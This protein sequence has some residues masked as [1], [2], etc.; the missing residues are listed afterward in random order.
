MPDYDKIKQE[1][2]TLDLAQVAAAGYEALEPDDSYRLKTYGIC[3]QRHEGYFMIRIRVPHGQCSVA[4]LRQL[5]DLADRYSNGWVHITTR[6]DVQLHSVKLEDVP[7]L[8]AGLASVDLST[9]SSCGHTFR[10]IMGC[11]RA[12]TCADERINVRPWV[13]LVDRFVTDHADHFNTRM[14]SRL[15][16]YFA[17]CDTCMEHLQINDIGL[18]AVPAE[19][20]RSGSVS[21]EFELWLGGS[22]G[23]ANPTLSVR[24][25]DRLQPAEV[26]PAVYAVA[27]VHATRSKRHPYQGRLKYLLQSLGQDAL[28]DCIRT[29]LAEVRADKDFSPYELPASP[30][31]GFRSARPEGAN[32][33]ALP[34]GVEPQAQ[35]GRYRVRAMVIRGDLT[36]RQTRGLADIAE[37]CADGWLQ[38]T[39][40]QNVEV[41]FVPLVHVEST[42]RRLRAA[43]LKPGDD[44]CLHDILVCPGTE[45]C[46][47]AITASPAAAATIQSHLPAALADDA[48]IRNVRIHISGCM[49]SCAQHQVADI[50]LSGSMTAHKTTKRFTYQL[51][52][53]G[54]LDC[55]P[56]RSTLGRVCRRGITDEQVVPTVIALLELYRSLRRAGE[57]FAEV[58]H[59]VGVEAF[60]EK[61]AEAYP[62][63]PLED[64]IDMP[65]SA[66]PATEARTWLAADC[67][68]A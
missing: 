50:G 67:E 27:E 5:A 58:V 6:M 12:G 24:Y 41:P 1:G 66:R 14:P 32:G 4:Q 62:P 9:R 53:G 57:S 17:G 39:P 8:L 33:Q 11:H 16:V 51:W 10:N 56:A 21:L 37:A 68:K 40:Q 45:Y 25:P 46:N 28:F 61:L 54:R 23:R 47:L 60:A 48:R 22:L 13:E 19:T 64:L 44:R 29:K 31:E 65:I 36:S 38:W 3:T 55:E 15:N 42:V 52:L 59:R 30:L 7:A 34:T 2:L 49:N 20:V 63:T 43:G 35:A 26:L 18:R